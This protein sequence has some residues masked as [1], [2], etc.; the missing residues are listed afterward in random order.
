[1][2][3][4]KRFIVSDGDVA[5]VIDGRGIDYGVSLILSQPCGY[6][7]FAGFE[8]AFGKRY[9]CA[10]CDELTP[11]FAHIM[12]QL[13]GACED[14][15]TGCLSGQTMDDVYVR[16]RVLFLYIRA[17]DRHDGC[18]FAPRSSSDCQQ[19]RLLVDHNEVVVLIDDLEFG[20]S[21]L[22]VTPSG[23]DGN[24]IPGFEGKIMPSLNGVSYFD[25]SLTQ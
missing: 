6:F 19:P 23:R 8:Y 24:N 17:E 5:A 16:A 1:M 12:L 14:E 7:P 21:E 9:I 11:V 4:A 22:A 10:V 25:A 13:L 15:Q 18:L 2:A 3:D 20:V